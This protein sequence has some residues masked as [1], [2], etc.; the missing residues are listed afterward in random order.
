[1]WMQ[2]RREPGGAVEEPSRSCG[3]AAVD[4]A[5]ATHRSQNIPCILIEGGAIT[6]ALAGR[7]AGNVRSDPRLYPKMSVLKVRSRRGSPREPRRAEG[8]QGPGS[9][10]Q[11]PVGAS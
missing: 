10:V 3:A 4:R 11:G 5:P 1:M 2:T 7:S 8:V 6:K 9:R